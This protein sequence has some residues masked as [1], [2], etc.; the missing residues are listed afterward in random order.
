MSITSHHVPW[1]QPCA[2]HKQDISS[3]SNLQLSISVWEF[4]AVDGKLDLSILKLN[5]CYV[6]PQNVQIVGRQ[7]QLNSSCE[8]TCGR[9]PQFESVINK[10]LPA[11][12]KPG[13]GKPDLFIFSP[14]SLAVLHMSWLCWSSSSIDAVAPVQT[15][16]SLFRICNISRSNS[17]HCSPKIVR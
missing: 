11:G 15:C 14:A 3:I 17:L 7:T 1:L 16:H 8:I 12:N 13:V 9:R 10:P 2:Y 4:A 5:V 6:R